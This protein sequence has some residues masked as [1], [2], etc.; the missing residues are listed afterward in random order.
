MK[1]AKGGI[2]MKSNGSSIPVSPKKGKKFTLEEIQKMVGGY[3]ERLKL[4]GRYVMLINEEGLIFKL[5]LNR[6]ASEIA[7]RPIV[8][9]VV[10]LPS[11]MGW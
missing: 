7:Q 1:A 11:G 9:D 6:E 4:P 2:W 3:V 8:G 5:P 10:V